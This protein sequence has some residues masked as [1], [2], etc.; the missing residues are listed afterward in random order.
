MFKKI[1]YIL[2]FTFFTA[3]INADVVKKIEIDGNKKVS[4]ETIKIYEKIE[5]N[6]NLNENDLNKI[7]QN[8]YETNFFE[9]VSVNLE[10]KYFKNSFKRISNN[11][12][13][14]NLR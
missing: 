13:I 3:A 10:G 2:V 1:I 5:L 8:L 11:K 9:N 4:D 6:T 14:N 12:S 7:L